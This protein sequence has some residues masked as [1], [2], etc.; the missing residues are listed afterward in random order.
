MVVLPPCKFHL[1]IL[2]HIYFIYVVFSDGNYYYFKL[3]VF[4]VLAAMLIE[5]I[6][7]QI[8]QNQFIHQ[9]QQQH[10]EQGIP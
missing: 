9:Q 1:F 6:D 3:F 4:D 5:P 8:E 7:F 2:L 10:Q